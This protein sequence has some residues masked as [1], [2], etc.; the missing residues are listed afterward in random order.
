[1]P[2]SLSVSVLLCVLVLSDCAMCVC[3]RELSMCEC[4]GVCVGLSVGRLDS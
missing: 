3:D 4:V 2:V 1:V